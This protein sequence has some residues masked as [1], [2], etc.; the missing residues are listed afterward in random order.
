MRARTATPD[1]RAALWPRLVELYADFAKYQKWTEREIPV[2]VLERRADEGDPMPAFTRAELEG[3]FATTRRSSRVLAS[4]DWAPFADNSPRTS[5]T[6]ST[7][8]ARWT[9]ARPCASGSRR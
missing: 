9:V 5:T 3:A 2:V 1:E 6:S 4:G 7:P 8:T